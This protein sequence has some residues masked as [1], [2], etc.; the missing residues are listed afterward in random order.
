MRKTLRA[1][2]LAT[3]YLVFLAIAF[4]SGY[5]LGFIHGHDE[6]QALGPPRKAAEGLPFLHRKIDPDF[7]ARDF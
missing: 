5:T 7:P 3:A 1:T 2:V 4:L 6:G